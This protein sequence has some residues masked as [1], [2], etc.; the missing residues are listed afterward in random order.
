M[1]YCKECG[2]EYRSGVKVCPDCQAQLVEGDLLLC[3]E[4]DEPVTE[5]VPFCNHCGVVLEW[6]EIDGSPIMCATHRANE[7]TGSCVVC[8]KAVCP[9]C[10]AMRFGRFFCN[11]DKHVETAFNWVVVATTSTDYEAQMIKANLEGAGIPATVLSKKDHTYVT[12]MGDLA[13]TEVLVPSQM[14]EDAKQF[15]REMDE[16]KSD[17][18]PH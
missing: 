5:E 9:E 3:H 4:C 12:T 16:L 14:V 1:P 13:V 18:D 17:T 7:A 8:K 2:Y 6:G 11:D 10:V 15:L